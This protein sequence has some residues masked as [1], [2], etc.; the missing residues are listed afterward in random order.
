MLCVLKYIF[1]ILISNFSTVSRFISN[2]VQPECIWYG[3]KV[4]RLI[5]PK[6][7]WLLLLIPRTEVQLNIQVEEQVFQTFLKI[8]ANFPKYKCTIYCY[9]I[10]FKFKYT[11]Y[12]S[13]ILLIYN[14]YLEHKYAIW[15]SQN[16][17]CLDNSEYIFRI[18]VF[19]LI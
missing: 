15:I 12:N 10:Y 4:S 7:N 18:S 19:D 14:T 2:E 6:H 8:S 1:C 5:K 17:S 16:L 11:I 3:F 13:N 9:T